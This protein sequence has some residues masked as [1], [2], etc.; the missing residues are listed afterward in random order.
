MGLLENQMK[1]KDTVKVRLKEMG[2]M[3]LNHN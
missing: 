2:R 1:W 3:V